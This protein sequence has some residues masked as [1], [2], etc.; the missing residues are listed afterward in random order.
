MG[1]ACTRIFIVRRLGGTN[2]VTPVAM[3]HSYH[4]GRM[5]GVISSQ[6]AVSVFL[7]TVHGHFHHVDGA[8]SVLGA[9]WLSALPKGSTCPSGEAETCR[10]VS[11]AFDDA[12][13]S[14]EVERCRP[15]CPIVPKASLQGSGEID[16]C[17]S[18]LERL[19]C[20]QC[21]LGPLW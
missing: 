14:G 21:S 18:C 2:I 20:Y 6:G 13:G 10:G 17:R 5:T 9:P 1:G 7:L 19:T 8:S 15:G 16:F 12:G 3:R 4:H 11:S